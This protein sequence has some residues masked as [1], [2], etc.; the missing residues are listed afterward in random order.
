MFADP[1]PLVTIIDNS[2]RQDR[3][4][5]GTTRPITSRSCSPSSSR[6]NYV[7]GAHSLRVGMHAS[8]RRGGGSRSSTP[9]TCSRS[10]TTPACP[11]SVTL[12]IP[13]DRRNSI[14][15]RHGPLRAGQVDDQ[16]RDDQ[17]RRP[18]RP[19]HRR[20]RMPET[21]PASTLQP[22]GHLSATA[23]T[24][25]QQPERRAA[26]AA[27][28]NWKDISPRVGVS[29][30][31][32]GNGK[33]AVKASVAR[34]VAGIGLAAGS[35]TD[36]NNP[37]ITVGL[38]DTRAWTRPR[39][40]RLAVRRRRRRFSSNE[41]TNS[42]STP[43][44]G[45][46][47]PS[48][49]TDRSG[50]AQRLGHARLQLGIHGQRAARARAA[51]VGQRRLVPPLVRQ[52]DGHGRQP[53]QLRQQQ[54]RRPVLR[55]RA[56][57]SEPAGRRRLPGVRPLRPEAVGGRRRTCRPTARFTFSYELRRRDEHLRGLRRLDRRRAFKRGRVPAAAASTRR[58]ASSISATWSTPASSSARDHRGATRGRRDLPGRHA[59][60]AIRICRIV[61]TSSCSART[62]CRC[63]IQCQRDV[64]VHPRRADRRRGA[65]H[66]RDL[67]DA[68]PA[69][70]TTLGRA[71]SA[72][73]TTKSVNLMAVG[74]ELRQR[75]PEAARR[76][77]FSKRFK[78]DKLPV[79]RR[80]RRLQPVQQR[81]AVHGQQHVLDGGDQ[82]LAAADQRAAGAVLQDRRAVR[83]LRRTG[84]DRRHCKS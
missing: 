47:V 72:G 60:R 61:P 11:V 18:L 46:N 2:D 80:L 38:T 43:S 34:Y 33:T 10:P 13:T 84:L 56:G 55:Q 5:R 12:R 23:R 49:T 57:R 79:P 29:F 68:R 59:A 7:T 48:S 14:D 30:D 66:P 27:C 65:E 41:L 36:N 26:P 17:R 21:L 70:A 69:S 44:F 63:D 83:L 77:R 42:T 19:V 67:D 81:L 39:R 73:A 50:G 78:L 6:A 28:I 32:F 8:A 45:K 22:G 3:R 20:R 16:P 74:A 15:A 4:T 51:R 62:R 25:S 64:P 40:Q 76:P 35:T 53:L 71:Y 24:A 58:S 54:L 82:Q 1:V 31:V 37:E 75:Q 9:A 52:P